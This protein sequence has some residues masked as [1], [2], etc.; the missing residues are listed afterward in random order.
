MVENRYEIEIKFY[1]C[2]GIAISYL[3]CIYYEVN[4]T[5][6]WLVPLLYGK[7]TNTLLIQNNC[8]LGRI[9]YV[10]SYIIFITENLTTLKKNNHLSYYVF[11]TYFRAP[12]NTI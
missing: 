3:S 7:I 2:D 10:F 4:F 6:K 12:Y 8:C 11:S 1:V 5:E 9:K